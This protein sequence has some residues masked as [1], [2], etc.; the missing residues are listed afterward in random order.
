ME[1]LDSRT[2]ISDP[3]RL[4]LFLVLAGIGAAV[5][6]SSLHWRVF[7]VDPGDPSTSLLAI[8]MD[9]SF[10]VLGGLFYA[11]FLK[12]PVKWAM[13]AGKNWRAAI[14]AASLAGGLL[15]AMATTSALEGSYLACGVILTRRAIVVAPG[16]G[17]GDAVL[18]S[19]IDVETYGLIETFIFVI[20]GFVVGA[21]A[22]VL[23]AWWLRPKYPPPANSTLPIGPAPT[24]I[25]EKSSI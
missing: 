17:L 24:Q 7:H 14:F 12:W 16:I 19:L 21:L 25:P 6:L 20:P 4:K 2:S 15:G 13:R 9:T 5:H 3:P 11:L 10:V 1:N 8:V 22:T 18:L 23:A